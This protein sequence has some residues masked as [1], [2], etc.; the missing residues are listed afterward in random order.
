MKSKLKKRKCKVCGELYVMYNSLRPY[1]S[2]SCGAKYALK[3][4]ANKETKEWKEKKKAMKEALLTHKDYIKL[5]QKVFNEYIRLRDQ[6]LPCVSCGV[7]ICE[8]FHAG[9]WIAST[10]QYLRFYENNVWKQ[11]SRCNTHLRGNPIPYRIELLKRVGLE[12][13]EYME[14]ARHMMLDISIPEIKEKIK[15]YKAKI[16]DLKLP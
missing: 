8:E 14:N 13:V 10:Y 2:P 6:E 5:Y 4:K 15:E 1:C 3:L 7:Y 9:H 16:K 11:C 12:E